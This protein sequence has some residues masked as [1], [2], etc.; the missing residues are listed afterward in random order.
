MRRLTALIA[1][2]VVVP[3]L[4]FGAGCNQAHSAPPVIQPA[5]EAPPPA[6]QAAPP[7]STAALPPAPVPA[8]FDV[9][10]L[11]DQVKPMV[12]NITTT[13]KVSVRGGE[14]MDDFEF[15]FG[16]RGPSPGPQRERSLKRQALGTGVIIDPGG[17]VVTNEH[18]IH[19]ADEV[20]VRL[21]D[22]RELKATV[23]GRDPMLDVAL[24]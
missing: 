6:A 10:N 13:Q 8:T 3:V 19:E 18:V 22:D 12:V 5:S 4:A 7:I 17:Y 21:S 1:P 9:A 24:L 14:G 16:G 15:F 11:A 20:R 2:F 23:V